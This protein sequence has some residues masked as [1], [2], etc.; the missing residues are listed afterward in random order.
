MLS[1]KSSEKGVGRGNIHGYNICLLQ[2][3]LCVMEFAKYPLANGQWTPH[4]SLIVLAALP[5]LLNRLDLELSPFCPSIS[6]PHLTEVRESVARW[7]L[8]FQMGSTHCITVKKPT[9][10]T[11][12]SICR[13]HVDICDSRSQLLDWEELSRVIKLSESGK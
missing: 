5:H 10:N 13:V 12:H 1:N 7:G 4:F 9:I 6:L 11:L 8:S 3:P 2:E